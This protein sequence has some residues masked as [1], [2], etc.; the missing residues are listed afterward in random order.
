MRAPAPADA[1]VPDAGIEDHEVSAR[2]RATTA[3]TGARAETDALP[4][5][6]ALAG[7]HAVAVSR[8]VE[9]VVGWQAVE[10]AASRLVPPVLAIADVLGAST[11][12]ADLPVVLLVAEDDHPMAAAAAAARAAAV[13]AWPA[14]RDQLAETATA[15]SAIAPMRRETLELSVGGAVGGV[16][17]TIVAL[18]L[19][20][21]VAW[22]RQPTLV[23]THGAV[24]GPGGRGLSPEEL[25]GVSLWDLAAPSPGVPNL[26]VLRLPVPV[27]AQM[28]EAGPATLVVRDLGVEVAGDVLVIRRDRPGLEALTRSAAAVVVVMDTGPAPLRLL[29]RAAGGR[30]LVTLPW[31]A[32]VAQAAFVGRIPAGLPGSWLRTLAPVLAGARR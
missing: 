27:P 26:R 9:S 32:R 6:L 20:G 21:L 13:V 14:D 18:A 5:H 2:R 3:A 31:S 30:R 7:T 1:A 22:R 29:A 25:V 11:A 17:T 8:W 19:G 4:V 23:L 12:P 16:G 10:A 15:V 28:G 24:P